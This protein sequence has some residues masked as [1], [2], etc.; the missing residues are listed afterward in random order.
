MK[1]AEQLSLFPQRTNAK[2]IEVAPGK[3]IVDLPPAAVPRVA[4]VDLV[5]TG[6]PS[7]Y[8]AVARVHTAQLRLTPDTIKKLNLGVKFETLKRLVRAGFVEGGRISPNCYLFDLASY[9]AHNDRVRAAA[10]AGE[11]F[12]TAE[13][14]T[15]YRTAI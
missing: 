2:T 6:D 10:A 3:T 7:T 13:N 1:A 9:Y 8:K 15:K 4:V 11:E 14:L 5:P 12:W